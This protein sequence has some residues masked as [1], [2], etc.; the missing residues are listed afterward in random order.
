M[1]NT[2]TQ[3]LMNGSSG[4]SVSK[5]QE[6][7][8]KN[9]YSL[10]VDGKFGP[11][12]QAAVEDYQ[13]KKG[14]TVDGKVGNETWG[15]L[16]STNQTSNSNSPPASTGFTYADYVESDTV[17]QAN[18]ALQAHMAAK[19]GEFSSE[20]TGQKND[21]ITRI[22]NREDFSYDVNSD[23]LYQQYKEQYS[24][25]GKLA[26]QDTMG[27][28]AAMT[29]GYGNSYAS[30]AGNQAYQ[31]YLSQLNEV[32]PELYGMA[33]DRYN[34]EGQEMYNQYGLLA[35]QE[36]RDYGRYRDS[37][38]DW[39]TE[40]DYLQ[41]VYSDERNFDYG[42]YS[43]NKNLAYNEYRN[44]ILDKQWQM[45]FD[46]G[47][48]QFDTTMDYQKDRDKVTDSQW[49][50]SHQLSVNADNRAQA[51]YEDSTKSYSGTTA[52]GTKFNNG[53]LTNG[54]IKEL[55]AAIGVDADGY[56]GPASQEAAEGLSAEEAYAKFVGGSTEELPYLTSLEEIQGW[57]DAILNAE[58]EAEVLNLVEALEKIDPALADN[59]YDRWNTRKNGVVPNNFRVDRLQ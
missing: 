16:T 18:N 32:V 19:P 37:V 27:Q 23:A 43:D 21:L 55:Q 12:T 41:G 28:A 57:T 49:Q 17:K 39:M 29:G 7:L 58:S 53:S 40:R 46:E 51:E 50:Q 52:N 38:S 1:S 30:S 11:K 42:V 59:L 48:R 47:V 34:A 26:M 13:N 2:L 20:W 36:D 35:D 33:L 24:A 25:L 9:G 10:D 54:Q 8:N 6:L 4:G 31:Q 44:A 14:L 3:I 5:L 15:S 22:L 45:D 56:Y